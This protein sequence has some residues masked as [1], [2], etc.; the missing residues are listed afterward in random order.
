[1]VRC[2]LTRIVP[3]LLFLC[4][5]TPSHA[6][7]QVVVGFGVGPGYYGAGAYGNG[8]YRYG[9]YPGANPYWNYPG[10]PGGPYLTNNYPFVGWPGY[11]GAFGSY[12]T[13][14]LSLY[15]PP[16]P[17]YGSIPG[18]LGNSDLVNQWRSSPTLGGGVSVYGWAGPFRASPRP[19]HPS[20]GVWPM[21]ERVG[22]VAVADPKVAV[23]EAA[24]AQ[25]LYLS[26]KVPQPSAEVFVDGV[27]TAQT[28]T[29][30]LYESPPLTGDKEYGYEITARWVERGATVEKKKSVKG[31]P[32]EVIRVDLTQ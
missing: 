17:V 4:V 8:L 22:E 25:V 29:D 21:M 6:S 23:N 9:R 31:K 26:V 15:G 12:W 3:S 7:A 5:L 14:G 28:G 32:G 13:N 30:R 20:V 19:R 24:A 27:K 11:T 10:L 16:V 2:L 18:V 1:M